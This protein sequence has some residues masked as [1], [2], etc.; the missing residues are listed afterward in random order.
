MTGLSREQKAALDRHLTTP[1]E[2]RWP[3]LEPAEGPV[4]RW[5]ETATHE[6]RR[7]VQRTLGDLHVGKS[8]GDRVMI[9]RSK[10][11][12]QELDEELCERRK[13]RKRERGIICR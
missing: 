9:L 12:L 8:I 5:P 3:D 10:E 11:S 7:R 1:P 13:E 2:E 4:R 6:L